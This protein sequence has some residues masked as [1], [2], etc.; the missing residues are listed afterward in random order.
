M[1]NHKR[2]FSRMISKNCSMR[3][4]RL[5]FFLFIYTRY[6][7]YWRSNSWHSST[8]VSRSDDD[9]FPPCSCSEKV[10]LHG[11]VTPCNG[12]RCSSRAG[13]EAPAA[14]LDTGSLNHALVCNSL[15]RATYRS[16]VL[17][18]PSRR[19]LRRSAPIAKRR[20]TGRTVKIKNA[21]ASRLRSTALSLSL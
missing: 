8:L 6:S 16:T 12:Q 13:P 7:S 20:L 11:G 9:L 4:I 2:T 14:F 19:A 15:Q 10:A 5:N 21:I 17:C 3:S 1:I 18:A